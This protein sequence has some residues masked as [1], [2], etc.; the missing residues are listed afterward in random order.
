MHEALCTTILSYKVTGNLVVH[1]CNGAQ[2]IVPEENSP[3][4]GLGFG[5]EWGSNF[6]KTACNKIIGI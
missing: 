4:L 5:S 6:P 3:R 2:I 1:A